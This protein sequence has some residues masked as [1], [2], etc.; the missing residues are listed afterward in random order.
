M[1]EETP[2]CHVSLFV[3]WSCL[4]LCKVFL[5]VWVLPVIRAKKF[6]HAWRK[7][8]KTLKLKSRL[9]CY[10]AFYKDI[11]LADYAILPFIPFVVVS[12]FTAVQFVVVCRELLFIA[13]SL[14]VFVVSSIRSGCVHR[15][16]R[17][18]SS[19]CISVNQDHIRHWTHGGQ[20]T[21]LFLAPR[22]LGTM[23]TWQGLGGSYSGLLYIVLQC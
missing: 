23:D 20:G 21:H 5:Y 4:D 6:F 17:E 14:S 3:P 11:L 10:V 22:L 12:L 7:H 15:Q 13:K 9:F 19:R 1:D 16:R 2:V 18:S 8:C